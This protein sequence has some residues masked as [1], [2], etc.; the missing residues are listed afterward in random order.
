VEFNKN[1]VYLHK[2]IFALPLLT[3]MLPPAGAQDRAVGAA[4]PQ[5][6][7]RPVNKTL[8]NK[9]LCLQLVLIV[10]KYGVICVHEKIAES[11]NNSR[12][13]LLAGH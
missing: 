7:P 13:I 6:D 3:L 5:V 1:S 12:S 9:F 11:Q 4:H 10:I 8:F 2:A